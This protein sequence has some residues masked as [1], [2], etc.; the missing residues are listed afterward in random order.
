MLNLWLKAAPLQ[1]VGAP[2]KASPV[3]LSDSIARSRVA[4]ME[5]CLGTGPE[6][7]LMRA[8]RAACYMKTH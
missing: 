5:P 6:K 8:P 2:A 3:L 4:A 1:H 7:F